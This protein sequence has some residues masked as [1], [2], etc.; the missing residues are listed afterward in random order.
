MGVR[1]EEI[2]EVVDRIERIRAFG[3]G[4]IEVVWKA[5]DMFSLES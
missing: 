1:V 2:W 4:R 5:G 3:E